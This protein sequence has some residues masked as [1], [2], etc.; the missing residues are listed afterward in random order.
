MRHP[1]VDEGIACKG[2]AAESSAF[3]VRNKT[4]LFARETQMMVKLDE[5]LPEATRLAQEDPSHY[6]VG[7][8][9]VT[10]KFGSLPAREMLVRWIAESYRIM[11]GA[12]GAAVKKT[13]RR[14]GPS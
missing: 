9:W 10:V 3:K 12:G 6:R 2:T 11:A 5:S 14:P 4:F 13:V 1:G 8:G 7:S